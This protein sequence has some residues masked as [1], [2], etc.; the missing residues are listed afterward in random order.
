M[1]HHGNFGIRQATNGL[2]LVDATFQFDRR[3]TGAFD[4]LAGI[5][6][7]LFR[8]DIEGQERQIDDHQCRLDCSADH[9]GMVDDFLESD[10]K[11]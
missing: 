6:N 5:A 4:D 9:L 11:C 3:G 8:A 2:C 7:G 1:R 10:W